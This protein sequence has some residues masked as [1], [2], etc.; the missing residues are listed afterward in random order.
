MPQRVVL[1][2]MREVQVAVLDS[3]ITAAAKIINYYPTIDRVLFLGQILCA[4][5]GAVLNLHFFT[6]NSF[7]EL[8]KI[9]R[10]TTKPHPKSVQLQELL[11]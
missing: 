10:L 5:T 2:E 1:L 6:G 7:R 4:E 8:D 11:T 3:V 9:T